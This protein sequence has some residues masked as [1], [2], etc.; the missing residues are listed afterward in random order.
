MSH[1]DLNVY[2]EVTFVSGTSSGNDDNGHGTAVAGIAAAKDN[3]DGVVGIAPGARL[4][5]IKVLDSSGN[6]FI[7]DIIEGVD[8]LN[9]QMK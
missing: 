3:S 6:G 5:S 8:Y 1:P 7:S 4:W 9:M 2:S